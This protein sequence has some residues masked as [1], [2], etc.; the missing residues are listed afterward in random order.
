VW[1]TSR[2][3]TGEG[4]YIYFGIQ[5]NSKQLLSWTLE[6]GIRIQSNNGSGGPP[7]PGQNI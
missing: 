1:K 6:G 2:R 5:L 3:I 4:V 7:I